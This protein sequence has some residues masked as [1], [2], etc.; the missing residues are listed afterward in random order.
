MRRLITNI[1]DVWK[2]VQEHAGQTFAFDTETSGLSFKKERLLGVALYF[3]NEDAYY[4]VTEH[5]VKMWDGTVQIANFVDRDALTYALTPLFGQQN[6]LM[7]AHNAK[8]DL[9][10]L[11]RMGVNLQGRLFDTLLAAQLLDENRSNG[12]KDL[13][14][15]VGI[16]YDKRSEEHT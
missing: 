15:L 4:I 2:L 11:S 7:I 9:H 3:E 6:T 13:S 5:T 10:F 14:H 16:T 8:F 1:D 12:L